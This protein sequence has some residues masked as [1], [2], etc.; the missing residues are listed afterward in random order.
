M[1]HFFVAAMATAILLASCSKSADPG[2]QSVETGQLDIE[3]DNIAGGQDLQLKSG[4]YTN[5]LNEQ[6]T[7]NTFNYFISNIKLQHTDG[8]I[9]TV[10][11]NDSYFL[12]KEEN[13]AQFISLTN[14]PAGNYNGISFVLGI[15]SL[16][17]SQPIENRTGVLDPATGAAGMYR[18]GN[19]GYI[20]LK[21]EGSSTALP[22]TDKNFFYHIGGFGGYSSPTIN[23]IKNIILTAAAGAQ[24][25]VRKNKTEAPHMHIFADVL[26]LFNGPIPIS[27]ATHPQVTFEPFSI[28]I[29]NNYQNMFSIDHIHN[30]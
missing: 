7:V 22:A 13:P 9:Y 8:S 14:I 1:K 29:A 5:S 6:F 27:I 15:D 4:N 3:F 19:L 12:I 17:S 10:P 24:A 25:E 23:N 28:N 21:L 2:F 20:F 30:D 26:K 18:D 16:K 11:Q